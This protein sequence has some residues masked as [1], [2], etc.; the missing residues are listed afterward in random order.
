MTEQSDHPERDPVKRWTMILILLAALLIGW[1]L[2]ADRFTPYT[3]QARVHAL[4]VPVAA[5][6]S[7]RVTEVAVSNNQPV[8]AGDLL[9]TIDPDKYKLDRNNAKANLQSAQAAVEKASKDLQRMRRIRKQDRGAI[10]ERRIDS[11]KASLDSARGKLDA[12]RARL[13]QAELNLQHSQIFAPENG[14]VTNVQI[15]KGHFAAA[16]KPLLTFISRQSIWLQADFTEN[17]LGHIKPGDPAKLIF[18]MLPGQVFAGRV[19]ELGFGVSLGP[20]PTGGLPSVKNE[21]DWLRAAQRFPVIIDFDYPAGDD[22]QPLTLRLG[23]QASAIVLTG[24]HPLLNTLAVI[25]IRLA[26]LLSYA[27]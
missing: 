27:Y 7:G 20:T 11:A 24:D 10:S 18:D 14:V 3:S 16:G 23:S 2:V 4:V 22:G 13:A 17:N 9:L 26:A 25:Q 1:H 15:S 8:K 12:A 21:R 6:I 19:R 5:E